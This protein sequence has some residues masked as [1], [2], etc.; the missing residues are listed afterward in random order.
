LTA[1]RPH[2]DR[3]PQVGTTDTK[4]C[5]LMAGTGVAIPPG[6]GIV[7]ATIVAIA[8]A[9]TVG[10]VTS[11]GYRRELV[12]FVGYMSLMVANA[13]A[14]LVLRPV[15][16]R[17]ELGPGY[18]LHERGGQR[19]VFMMDDLRGI[20]VGPEAVEVV[21]GNGSARIGQEMPCWQ[22]WA[23][24][25]GAAAGVAGGTGLGEPG[26]PPPVGF[27]EPVQ[28]R[29]ARGASGL[30]EAIE[31]CLLLLAAEMAWT[32]ALLPLP[33]PAVA[34]I[35][36]T[37]GSVGLYVLA[38]RWTGQR[39]GAGIVVA[40]PD[41]LVAVR[42]GRADPLLAWVDLLAVVHGGKVVTVASASYVLYVDVSDPACTAIV[43]AAEQVLSAK[44]LLA[45]RQGGS[46][47]TA[48]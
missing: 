32:L 16:S 22:A 26:D 6:W 20:Q 28:C 40:S 36:A 47:E 30:Q 31:R 41:G 8:A 11:S 3:R 34:A 19:R 33:V 37:L 13:A 9:T 23:A 14:M 43:A 1:A 5:V 45:M 12:F 42:R 48:F 2:P 46:T 39:A 21:F 4:S 27:A 25:I 17:V 35:V 29:L 24:A 15:L 44:G 18:L 10:A 7:C 38:C